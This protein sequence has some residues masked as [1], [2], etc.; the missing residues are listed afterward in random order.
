MNLDDA[1]LPNRVNY[2]QFLRS[3]KDISVFAIVSTQNQPMNL[4]SPYHYYA[5]IGV[6]TSSMFPQI[7]KDSHT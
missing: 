6:V 1:K 3:I 7:I 4:N 2:I 5:S